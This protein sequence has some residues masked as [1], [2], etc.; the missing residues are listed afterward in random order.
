MIP[1]VNYHLWEPCNMNCKFCFATFQDVKKNI[2][3]KGHLPKEKAINVIHQLAEIGFEKITFAGGEPTLCPWISDLIKTAKNLGMTTM[4]VTNGSKLTEDFLKTNKTNLDWIAISVDSLNALTN[5]TI[6]RTLSNKKL[7]DA[8]HY[9]PLCKKIKQ[10]GYGL[11]I[12][13]VVNSKNKDEEFVDFIKHSKPKRWKILQVLPM[14]EQ[15]DLHI[16]DMMVTNNEFKSFVKKHNILKDNT[17]IVVETNEQMKGSYAMVDPAGRFFDNA[18]G[19]HNYSKSINDIGARLAIQQVNYDF[20]KF[21]ERGGIYNWKDI[22]STRNITISGGVA[23]GKSTIGKL[24]AKKLNYEYVSL[25]SKA[26]E[27]AKSKDLDISDFQKYCIQNP[28]LDKE[29]DKLFS[30]ECNEKTNLIVDY[31]LGYKFIPK[32]FKVFLN[33]TERVAIE[34]LK[35]ANRMNETYQTLK[36]RE[37]SFRKQFYNNYGI[38]N[39]EE[40]ENYDMV[41]SVDNQNPNEIMK[42]IIE[43]FNNFLNN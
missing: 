23:S 38:I 31:R 3:P 16:E 14:K 19:V 8:E 15:N 42:C 27:I 7:F 6:G 11:K 12:N 33:V 35:K 26:R 9:Y 28:S 17:N 39:Y 1:S 22:K 2:L 25:G 10:Y 13:T 18:N 30:K 4:I 34:R 43:S 5:N 29:I 20:E 32:S 41:I 36:S 37:G 21:I 40:T 24:L